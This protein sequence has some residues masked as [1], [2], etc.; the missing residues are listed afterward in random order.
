MGANIK[1]KLFLFISCS[2][3]LGSKL[4]FIFNAS[5]TSP[6][7]HLEETA[8]LPCLA[9]LIFILDKS[10]AAAVEIFKVFLPSPP[11]PQV[12]MQL[13][14]ITLFDLFL[15][16]KTPPAISSA[17]SPLIDKKVKKLYISFSEAFPFINIS[18]ADLLSSKF[19]FCFLLSFF[20]KVCISFCN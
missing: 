12:S 18:N 16:T 7:P 1:P 11:V 15:R 17:T 13:S 6:D 20:K 10:K 8:L 9:T 4:I 5:N 19:K 14:T 2:I 3:S